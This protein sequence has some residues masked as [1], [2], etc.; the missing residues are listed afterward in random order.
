MN[1]ESMMSPGEH[2]SIS[3]QSI[4]EPGD[5]L[6]I[7]RP[8]RALFMMVGVWAPRLALVALVLCGS[9]LFLGLHDAPSARPA[10]LYRIIFIHA[11]AAWVS[12]ALYVLVAAFAGAGMIAHWRLPAMLA[13]AVAPTGAMFALVALATGALGDRQSA[14]TWWDIHL[15]LELVLLLLFVAIVLLRAAMEDGAWADRVAGII[16]LSGFACLPV[17]LG[18]PAHWPTLHR[19]LKEY[20]SG[21]D[22]MPVPGAA[23]AA[24]TAGFATY[25]LAVAL[26]RLRCIILE[27]DRGSDWV[28][29]HTGGLR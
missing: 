26:L 21:G 27:R 13:Q 6:G 20:Q 29:R 24:I 10:S 3:H 22:G 25:A 7:P 15:T 5:D 4:F 17:V 18:T 2:A 9:G 12:L 1:L 23:L 28:E 8:P 19:F 14:R 16:A 11:P